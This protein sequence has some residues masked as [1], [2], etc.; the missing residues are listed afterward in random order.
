MSIAETT[1]TIAQ[2]GGLHLRVAAQLVQTA[3]QFT[4]R[5]WIQ[6]VSRPDAAEIDAKSLFSVLQSGIAQG[7]QIRLRT[8]GPD[9]DVA[10]AALRA[11]IEQS[12]E[13]V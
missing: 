2:P 12:S 13:D 9:A 3:A 10:L 7:Q 4:S 6:N 11:L 1:L 8:E 5:V